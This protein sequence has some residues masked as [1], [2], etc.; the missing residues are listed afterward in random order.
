MITRNIVEVENI[1]VF[2]CKVMLVCGDSETV[3]EAM[4]RK[5]LKESFFE[6]VPFGFKDERISGFDS[7]CSLHNRTIVVQVC[8]ELEK[9]RLVNVISHEILH[10]VKYIMELMDTMVCDETEEI[11]AYT[12]GW[13]SKFM[14]DNIINYIE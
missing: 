6:S 4:I 1:G 11:C 2:Q 9:E 8:V 7:I 14:Y 13:L 10:T 12:T 5:G 3:K